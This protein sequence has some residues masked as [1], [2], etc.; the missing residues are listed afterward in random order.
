[1]LGLFSPNRPLAAVTILYSP[2]KDWAA[3]DFMPIFNDLLKASIPLLSLSISSQGW[4]T[5]DLLAAITSFFPHLQ[6]LS[7]H[8]ESP[9]DFVHP[10]FGRPRPESPDMQCPVLRDDAAFDNIPEDALSDAEDDKPPS[11]ALVRVPRQMEMSSSTTLHQMLHWILT[12]AASLPDE[13]EVLRF[14]SD[15][16]PLYWRD[17][18]LEEQDFSLEEQHEVIATLSHLYP[19]LRE[20]E[21]GYPESLWIREGAV[22]RKSGM[23]LYMQVVQAVS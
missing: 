18:S 23:D 6:E 12:G 4:P 10:I 2:L 15:E 5:L 17:F 3:G 13:I 20:L 11:V 14:I 7:V 19:H 9:P 16:P 8:L 21:M 22:W 1:M